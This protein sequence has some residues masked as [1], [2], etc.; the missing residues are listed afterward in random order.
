MSDMGDD[1]AKSLLKGCAIIF[2]ISAVVAFGLI[3]LINWLWHS[4]T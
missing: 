4:V 3:Y 1:I 2:I